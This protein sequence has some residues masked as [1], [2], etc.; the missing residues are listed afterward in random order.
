MNDELSETAASG[1]PEESV[2]AFHMQKSNFFRVVHC[3]GVWCSETPGRMVQLMFYS[4]R[5]PIPQQ[6]F[7][8]LNED[9]TLG[10]EL[11]E[12]RVIKQGYIREVE[13][14]ALMNRT[15]LQALQSWIG[16]YLERTKEPAKHETK[17]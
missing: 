12:Q 11:K 14:S 7:F 9:G 15:T 4:E 13:V 10:E 5:L 8:K 1:Q 17:L 6:T 16:D 3:D 2:A